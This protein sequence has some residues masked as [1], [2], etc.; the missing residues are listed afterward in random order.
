MS[1]RTRLGDDVIMAHVDGALPEKLNQQISDLV[2]QDA[3]SRRRGQALKEI[4]RLAQLAYQ[5]VLEEPTPFDLK[6][7]LEGASEGGT[8]EAETPAAEQSPFY[9][10]Q[11][12]QAP[13]EQSADQ[14]NAPETEDARQSHWGETTPRYRASAPYSD[15]ENRPDKPR[16]SER[17]RKR[18][19][20]R[21]QISQA[22]AALVLMALA[23]GV[24][25]WF[26]ERDAAGV[27]T[28]N[29]G[30]VASAPVFDERILPG[31]AI[32]TALEE[33]LSGET[34]QQA[35]MTATARMTY[36]D[37]EGRV[38]RQYEISGGGRAVVGV[39]CRLADS[40]WQPQMSVEA[41]IQDEQIRTVPG[42]SSA[43]EA[44]LVSSMASDALGPDRES[45]LIAQ[46]W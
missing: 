33:K 20:R 38:C 17:Q 32:F 24:G 37:S 19:R 18:N 27:S 36:R 30:A 44:Y 9:D 34:V 11:A 8:P 35:R 28:P 7:R 39:A 31:M 13:Q 42:G 40:R 3:G 14:A 10:P 5:D 12:A 26:G 41:V 16:L 2:E 29:L 45:Q 23:G 21:A 25:F 1:N 6:R 4:S 43:L 46:G 22:A 15:S